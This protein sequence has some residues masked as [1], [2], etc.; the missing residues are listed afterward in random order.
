MIENINSLINEYRP[1]GII[2]D[3]VI[4]LVYI[5]GSYDLDYISQFKRTDEYCAEDHKTISYVLSRFSR[6]VVTPHILAELSNLSV[7][8]RKE[9][10]EDYFKTF[11][12]LLKRTSED[13]IGKD[14][15]LSFPL[16]PKIGVTD[17]GI[18]EAAK[19]NNYLVFTNDKD[20]VGQAKKK[21][22]NV[23][24]LNDIRTLHWR[25]K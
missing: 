22:V 18:I 4:M 17:L 16:F 12:G 25:M 15:V 23:L 3:T 11:R 6:K 21:G 13:Y 1:R 5:V 24:R 20:L 7:Q 2:I 10:R 14:I 9:E 8:A 19:E